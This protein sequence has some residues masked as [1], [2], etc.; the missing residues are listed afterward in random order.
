[1][2]ASHK[3]RDAPL[4]LRIGGMDCADCAL[5]I[6]RAIAQLDAVETVSVNFTTETLEAWGE[7]DR[8]ALVA[9]INELG[10]STGASIDK[11]RHANTSRGVQGFLAFLWRRPGNRAAI[12][13]G[14]A[15]LAG[16]GLELAGRGAATLTAILQLA[17]IAVVGM[18]I[19]IRGLRS[20]LLARRIAIDLLIAVA[21]IGAVAIG[22]TGEAAA[23]VLL[24]T[25]GE[26]LEAYCAE[27]SRDSLRG[28]LR[29][30]PEQAIRLRRA[31]TTDTGAPDRLE[32]VA[33]TDLVP[34]DHILIRP[35]ERIPADGWVA[36]GRSSVD[37]SAL[38]GEALP[39]ERATGS[40]VFAG[41]INGEGT[42]R[43]EVSR[44]ADDFTIAQIARLVGEAQARK[45]AAERHV[46]RFAQW[47]TP[48]VVV[49]ALAV[50]SIPPLFFGQPFLGTA[51]P[52]PGWAYR[53]LALLIVACPCALVISI[54][55]TVVSALTRL[56]NLGVLVKGGAL[57]QELAQVRVFAFDK[58]GTL[59]RGQ[60]I[61]TGTRSPECAH[62][63]AASNGCEPCDDLVALA[64]AVAAGSEHPYA[65]AVVADAMSRSLADRYPV[66]ESITAHTGRGV[67]GQLAGREIT[68]GNVALLKAA[69]AAT[70]NAAALAQ[71][72]AEGRSLMLVSDA[73]RIKGCI[74]VEDELHPATRGTLEKLRELDPGYRFVMLTGDRRSVAER[75]AAAVGQFDDIRA[76]LLPDQ[77][78]EAVREL[79]QQ[80]GKAAMVGDG[81]NDAPALA[82]ARL[83]IAMGGAGSHHAMEVAD[84]V[85]MGDDLAQLPTA[86][87]ISRKTQRVIT[88]NIMLSL[89]LKLAFLALAIPGFATLWMAVLADVGATVL[90][91]LNGM[92]MLR[93]GDHP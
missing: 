47:Y 65:K 75:V 33:V 27:R 14:V 66:A 36:E 76:E 5:T 64:A 43:V 69:T 59:T 22:A 73:G 92:R 61:V 6:E 50:A 72:S 42:L 10:Y 53:G 38:T 46:D 54:P 29:L 8:D 55:V 49:V 67:S 84:I 90:V 82:A 57:L 39:V 70:A 63:G 11:P 85:L 13:L 23:V 3:G 35:G 34:G 77:K 21:A 32:P 16:L 26:A 62:D 9:R 79:E 86:V 31:E 81:I 56:A 28:L 15:L 7:F 58:T 71:D 40:E 18:P 1:M 17:T 44:L 20:L 60:P 30:R 74:Y 4:R 24:Y 45:S 91:T 12:V 68:V 52:D 25:L 80:S 88:E 19:G 83:G 41:T 37:E 48:A 93:A 78:L 89:G 2:V 87:A 51:L